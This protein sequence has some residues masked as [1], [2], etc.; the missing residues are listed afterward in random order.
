MKTNK[1]FQVSV[2][3]RALKRSGIDDDLIDVEALVDSELTLEENSRIIREEVE[4]IAERK[5]E[6]E[7]QSIKKIERYLEA[8][9]I[10]SKRKPSEQR[11]DYYKNAK[12]T[13]SKQDLKEHNFELWKNDPNRYDIEGIDMREG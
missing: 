6:P 5:K 12:K 10:F 8:V 7:T 13:F 2:I 3:R 11:I 4:S 1:P 9:K